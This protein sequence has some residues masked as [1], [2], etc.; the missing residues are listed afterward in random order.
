MAATAQER[1]AAAPSIYPD[2]AEFWEGASRGELLLAECARCGP[3]WYPRA[4]CPH[5]GAGRSGWLHA[6]GRGAIYSLSVTRRAGPV[7][8]AIAYVTLA[9]GITILTNIV[10]CDLDAL[11]IG[12][13]VELVFRHA[14]GGQA[15]PMFRPSR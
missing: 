7:P 14:E 9:E 3:Y 5:C 13:P 4:H 8:Y 2:N 1:L 15:V 12:D 11:A 10:D 6:C